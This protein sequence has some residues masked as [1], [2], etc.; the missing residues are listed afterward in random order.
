MPTPKARIEII[1]DTTGNVSFSSSSGNLV[2]IF[3]MLEVAKKIVLESKAPEEP[4]IVIPRL[5]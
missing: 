4:S 2:T 3:G 5:G 1:L